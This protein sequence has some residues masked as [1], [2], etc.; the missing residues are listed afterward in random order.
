MSKEV[1][2]TL[3]ARFTAHIDVTICIVSATTLVITVI[4]SMRV[5][6]MLCSFVATRCGVLVAS[7]P[8][9]HSMHA[10]LAS[11]IKASRAPSSAIGNR[12]TESVSRIVERILHNCTNRDGV[13]S[14]T[15]RQI[16]S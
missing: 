11:I 5:C 8:L 7:A 15:A 12:Q 4:F 3:I 6:P 10:V 14:S 9:K 13:R 1:T 16:H 2:K